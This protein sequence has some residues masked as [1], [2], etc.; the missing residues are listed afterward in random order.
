M[1]EVE[2]ALQGAQTRAKARAGGQVGQSRARG[3]TALHYL[4]QYPAR[5]GEALGVC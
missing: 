2:G 1:L 5:P 4:L 3:G